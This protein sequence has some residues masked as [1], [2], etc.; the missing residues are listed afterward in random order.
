MS[1]DTIPNMPPWKRLAF[2]AL[3]ALAVTFAVYQLCR[4]ATH[5]VISGGPRFHH[6]DVALATDPG[7]FWLTVLLWTGCT[8][9]MSAMALVFIAPSL[10]Q[11]SKL[12]GWLEPALKAAPQRQP[13]TREPIA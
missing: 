4:A 3:T 11:S 9:L 13:P 1:R 2:F 6:H 12:R 8:V 10:P 5:G 7:G